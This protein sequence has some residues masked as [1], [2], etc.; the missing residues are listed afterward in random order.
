MTAEA[1]ELTISAIQEDYGTFILN[2]N[3]CFMLKAMEPESSE[4]VLNYSTSMIWYS[5]PA[6]Y[7]IAGITINRKPHLPDKHGIIMHFKL[8]SLG[9]N[10]LSQHEMHSVKEL[11]AEADRGIVFPVEEAKKA[12]KYLVQM[13]N[14]KGI[15]KMIDFF[16]LLKIMCESGEKRLSLLGKL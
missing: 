5:L 6:I 8:G 1:L 13:I 3:L 7:L 12:E 16:S 10:L 2:M 15:D 9:D 11:L 4:I 14:N